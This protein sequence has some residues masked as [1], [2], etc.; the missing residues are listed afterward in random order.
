MFWRALAVTSGFACLLLARSTADEPAP[1]TAKQALQGF[2]DLIG[3]W[4]GTGTPVGSRE[5]Q[6]KNFWVEAMTWGWQFK[7][8]DAWLSITI[9]GGNVATTRIMAATDNLG[10]RSAVVLNLPN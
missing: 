8:N 1:P 2:N 7:G 5:E 6:Q 4:R 3:V 10:N 9:K